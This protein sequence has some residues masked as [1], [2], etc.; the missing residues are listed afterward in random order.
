MFAQISARL[1]KVTEK[2]TASSVSNVFSVIIRKPFVAPG[3]RLVSAKIR[4]GNQ[5]ENHFKIERTS[6]AENIILHFSLLRIRTFTDFEPM[7]FCVIEVSSTI[8][9]IVKVRVSFNR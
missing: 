3:C 7:L 8:L 9:Q 1:P 6:K 4:F 5:P 2:L